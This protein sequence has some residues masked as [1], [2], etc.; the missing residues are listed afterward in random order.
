MKTAKVYP[1]GYLIMI[2][3]GTVKGNG[4]AFL[5]LLERGESTSLHIIYSNVLFV[6]RVTWS[7]V[8]DS[9]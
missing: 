6:D 5:K 4:A 1:N 3:V 9:R 7:L 2:I 8:F